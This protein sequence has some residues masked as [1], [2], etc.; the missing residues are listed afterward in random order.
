MSCLAHA[1]RPETLQRD[2]TFVHEDRRTATPRLAFIFLS[3]KEVLF[4]PFESFDIPMTHSI[5]ATNLTVTSRHK[6]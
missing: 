6:L 3:V 1:V 2:V 5:S 4:I